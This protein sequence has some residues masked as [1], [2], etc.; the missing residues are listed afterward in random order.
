MR[1]PAEL[2]SARW[3]QDEVLPEALAEIMEIAEDMGETLLAD[4]DRGWAPG[5]NPDKSVESIKLDQ[6]LPM[7]PA[8]VQA[9]LTTM[10]QDPNLQAKAASLAAGYLQAMG[11]VRA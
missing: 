5:V 2:G 3:W 4:L 10:A 11:G 1:K 8:A 9:I 6:L 7:N